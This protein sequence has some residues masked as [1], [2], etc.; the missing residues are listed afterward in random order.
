MDTRI[1]RYEREQLIALLQRD[2]LKR[3]TF[4]LA[5]GRTSHYYVDG[6]KVTLSAQGAA[7]CRRRRARTARRSPEIKAVGG[8]TMGADPIVGATL[9]LAPSAGLGHL[10]GFLVRKEAKTHGTGNL[11]EGPLEPGSHGGDRRRRGDDRR[12][13][14]PGRPGRRGDGLQGRGRRRR[15]RSPRRSRRGVRRSRPAVSPALDHPRPRRRTAARAGL[16]AIRR[17]Q[18][19]SNAIANHDHDDQP[20]ES[21][22][23]GKSWRRACIARSRNGTRPGGADAPRSPSSGFRIDAVDE[24]GRL[25]EVQSGALG[26]LARQTAAVIARASHPHRQAGRLESHGS[27]GSRAATVPILSARCS[28]KRGALLD[29][30]DDL[31]GVVRVFPHANLEIE[32]LGVAIEEI[33]V[34]RRRWP[35][36][37]VVDRCLGEIHETTSLVQAG[38]LWALLPASLHMTGSR[39]PRMILRRSSIARSRLPSASRTACA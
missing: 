29:V 6:R 4:T 25:V 7:A 38:D 3:G 30:F 32:V 26:P 19:G 15:A 1:V 13:V 21:V 17:R 12:L 10:R 36:Y 33:R 2:A 37:R 20:S 35:G 22:S 8:L 28:P 27:C 9:A 39:S 14:A 23:G 34:P 16:A 24:A 11:I 18:P 5:S 31:I